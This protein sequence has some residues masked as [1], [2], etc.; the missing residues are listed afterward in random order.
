MN[1]ERVLAITKSDLLDAELL[2]E[3]SKEVPPGVPAIFISAAAQK[4]LD[5][6]KD[7]LWKAL[8][9]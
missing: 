2:K 4:G 7:M 5:A 6:L 3:L 8:H 9:A 1:K